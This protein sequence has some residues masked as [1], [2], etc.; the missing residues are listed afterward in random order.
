MSVLPDNLLRY[1]KFFGFM[2]K[3]WNSELFTQTAASAL[4]D[5]NENEKNETGYDQSPKELVDDLKQM[6][7]TYIKLGQLLS[8]RPDLLPDNYLK[9]LASLQDDVPSI[10]YSEVSKI[11]EEELGVRI[12]KAFTSFE[13]EPL[14]SASI[15]Q[16]HKAT[17]LRETCSGKDSAAGDKK[18]IPG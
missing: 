12:S 2:L 5:E 6:G 10:P 14:A 15:G 16:V 1:Q 3:Y 11:I 7:P 13:E 8:T 9:A 17:L 4:D 18:K